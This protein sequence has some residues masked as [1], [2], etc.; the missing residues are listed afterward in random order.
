MAHRQLQFLPEAEVSPCPTCGNTS[1]FAI[2]ADRCGEDNF[3]IYLRC[4]CGEYPSGD[5][6][7]EDVR[8]D[9]SLAMAG[10]AIDP[11]NEWCQEV[12]EGKKQPGQTGRRKHIGKQNDRADRASRF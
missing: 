6:M 12:A 7:I 2:V 4:V 3:E 1:N 11:W 8:D 9:T 5:H 10:A